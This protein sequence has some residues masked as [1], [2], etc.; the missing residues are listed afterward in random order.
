MDREMFYYLSQACV[1]LDIKDASRLFDLAVKAYNKNPEIDVVSV[2]YKALLCINFLNCCYHKN[3]EKK[4]ID[5]A[6]NTVLQLPA[7]PHIAYHKILAVYYRALFNKDYQ[8]AAT[9][10]EIF[11]E[12]GV[13][14]NVVDTLPIEE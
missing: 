9:M 11:T 6:I 3:G 1:L 4:Y 7:E 12:A 8:K 13:V 10:I 2:T 14:S 5:L